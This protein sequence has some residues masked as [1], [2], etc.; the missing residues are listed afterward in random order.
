MG[1]GDLYAGKLGS[2]VGGVQ[3]A[4]LDGD[5]HRVADSEVFVSCLRE[6]R[7]VERH[8]SCDMKPV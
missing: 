4:V 6:L 2:V 7:A 5:N 8:H 3:V 1:G